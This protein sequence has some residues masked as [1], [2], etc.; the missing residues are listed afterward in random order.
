MTTEFISIKE[1]VENHKGSFK[2]SCIK[3]SEL[4]AGT[5]KNGDWTMKKFTL[6]DTSGEVEIA[7]FNEEI[8]FFKVGQFYEVESPWFKEYLDR[9]NNKKYSCNIGQ[10]CKV[11]LVANPPTQTTM[12]TE[13]SSKETEPKSP[14]SVNG[15]ELTKLTVSKTL[16]VHEETIK[17][18]Q[19]EKEVRHTIEIYNPRLTI[20][21]GKIGMFTKE[22]YRKYE[23]KEE[24]KD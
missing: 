20:D 12:P 13:T 4:K 24:E 19:I 21:G 15:E 3:T 8:N 14:G 16:F 11:N 10:Y 2:G 5:G 6:Q 23:K 1:A 9:E 18:L 22:I 7:C 17:L